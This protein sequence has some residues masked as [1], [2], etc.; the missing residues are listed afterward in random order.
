MVYYPANIV[1][2]FRFLFVILFP[3]FWLSHPGAAILLGVSLQLLDSVDGY[4]A[5]RSGKV[6]KLGQALDM[7]VDRCFSLTFCFCMS[8]LFP[9]WFILF[10]FICIIDIGSHLLLL[11]SA[12]IF[13]ADSHKNLF[14]NA[15]SRLVKMYH[16]DR[17]MFMF[18]TCVFYDLSFA[19]VYIYHFYPYSIF[20]VLFGISVAIGFLKFYVHI[21]QSVEMF[22]KL[23]RLD[24]AG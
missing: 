4:I 20:M 11:Y 3:F 12:A 21:F 5:R 18:I 9:R 19:L 15:K 22:R 7:L 17:R 23:V 16:S 24:E 13:K 10:I 8:C 14:V 1:T 6:T 2:Y